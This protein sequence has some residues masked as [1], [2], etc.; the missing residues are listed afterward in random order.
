MS[1]NCCDSSYYRTPFNVKYQDMY[2][3]LAQKADTNLKTVVTS[4]YSYPVKEGYRIGGC[5]SGCGCGCGLSKVYLDHPMAEYYSHPNAYKF[6]VSNDKLKAENYDSRAY[7]MRNYVKNAQGC[8]TL[9]GVV[10]EKYDSRKYPVRE[11]SGNC[12]DGCPT[13]FL[14]TPFNVAYQNLY[15]PK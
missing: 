15:C 8:D 2:C 4:G 7:P 9:G 12:N 11:F 1:S 10:S 14:R 5:D 13:D 6:S 3:N